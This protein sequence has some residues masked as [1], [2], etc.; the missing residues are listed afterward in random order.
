MEGVR[1]G[2]R[3]YRSGGCVITPIV[4]SQVDIFLQARIGIDT[5]LPPSLPSFQ[6]HSFAP[7]IS[8]SQVHPAL[9]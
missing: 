1:E 8:P 2:V 3:E 4:T 6:E 9:L 5:S 7:Y